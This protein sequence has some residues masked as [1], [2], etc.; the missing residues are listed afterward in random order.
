MGSAHGVIP[1]TE[2]IIES[3][4][5]Q[6][7]PICQDRNKTETTT[8][9]HGFCT[10]CYDEWFVQRNMRT[11]PICRNS[12]AHVVT[13][14]DICEFIARFT[15]SHNITL[16][17]VYVKGTIAPMTEIE[18][19]EIERKISR[20]VDRVSTS[21]SSV[22]VGYDYVVLGKG[23]NFMMGRMTQRGVNEWTITK[24]ICMQRSGEIYPC[25]PSTR[26]I[27]S[28]NSPTFY[29]IT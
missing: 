2:N 12:N 18:A 4:D 3:E 17:H 7:C 11:C 14:D 1:S 6:L 9:D 10:I 27:S 21:I 29:R 16:N 28:N 15:E 20:S 22:V 23:N 26:T 24:C 5:N 25:K 19:L 13:D 8:C